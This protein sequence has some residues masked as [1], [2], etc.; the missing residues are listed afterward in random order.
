MANIYIYIVAVYMGYTVYLSLQNTPIYK[1]AYSEITQW[2]VN[3]NLW[4]AATFPFI[5]IFPTEKQASIRHVE[6]KDMP[7]WRKCRKKSTKTSR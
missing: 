7:T 2:Y 1:V 4:L 5:S 6:M 3:K